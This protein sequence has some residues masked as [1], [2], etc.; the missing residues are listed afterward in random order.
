M[1]IRNIIRLLATIILPS[2][3]AMV[4]QQL[5]PATSRSI[6]MWRDLAIAR[7][8]QRYLAPPCPRRRRRCRFGNLSAP[9][10]LQDKSNI[11]W[12]VCTNPSY[13][14]RSPTR[15]LPSL[16]LPSPNPTAPLLITRAVTSFSPYPT[17]PAG[18]ICP[19]PWL[20]PTKSL[21]AL[22]C[23]LLPSLSPSQAAST[24]IA[25]GGMGP[26]H[27]NNMAELG[28]W[29]LRVL[30]AILFLSMCCSAW[31]RGAPSGGAVAETPR[32]VVV[33]SL[34]KLAESFGVGVAP[35]SLAAPPPP[36]VLNAAEDSLVPTSPLALALPSSTETAAVTGEA[37]PT[38]SSNP[39][40]T[41]PALKIRAADTPAA[42]STPSRLQSGERADTLVPVPVI[43]DPVGVGAPSLQVLPTTPAALV[44]PSYHPRRKTVPRVWPSSSPCSGA[45]LADMLPY[46]PKTA[47]TNWPR[48]PIS[49]LRFEMVVVDEPTVSVS[50]GSAPAAPATDV[51]T[52]HAPRTPS[53]PFASPSHPST[54]PLSPTIASAALLLFP[55]TSPTAADLPVGLAESECSPVDT[56]TAAFS[57]MSIGVPSPSKRSPR[58]DTLS[59]SMSVSELEPLHAAK[60]E[61]AEA[62]AE[63]QDAV[64]PVRVLG[65]RGM[66][67]GKRHGRPGAASAAE[68]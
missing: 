57:S 20:T 8:H 56:L 59:L 60:P 13:I 39:P 3:P 18:P 32:L 50:S 10:R 43:T 34:D 19:L 27:A 66:R 64:R 5:S 14:S 51:S 54:V 22:A 9:F 44:Y 12:G 38:P 21:A 2:A 23:S 33:R 63:D 42:A 15:Q 4:E 37:A 29:V 25:E 58:A 26:A 62:R 11:T 40:V 47:S 41:P 53:H 6:A 68:T 16:L 17:S 24:L 48:E 61:V 55:A 35:G 36:G 45:L 49:P 46:S 52:A 7:F 31:R 67:E 30:V 1:L 65:D 28:W